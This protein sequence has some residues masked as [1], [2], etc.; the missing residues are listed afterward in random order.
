[1][2]T[3]ALA[4]P[5]TEKPLEDP[6]AYLPCASILEFRKGQFI[7]TRLQPATSLYLVISGKVKVSRQTDDGRQVTLGIYQA[8]DFFGEAAILSL[9][10]WGE[11]VTAIENTR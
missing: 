7:Y 11:Q 3:L 8:D 5:T 4:T 10:H 1:M 2:A 9:P 6:L